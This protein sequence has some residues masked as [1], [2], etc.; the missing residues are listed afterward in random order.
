M[1]NGS[2]YDYWVSEE[3]LNLIRGWRRKGMSQRDI[4]QTIKVDVS[5]F[6]VWARKFPEFAEAIHT[7]PD[8]AIN[9]TENALYKSAVGYWV[10]EETKES[11][12]V[13]D[14][15]TRTH[16]TLHKRYIA[17]VL[18]AQCFILKNRDLEHWKDHPGESASN[19]ED[20]VEIVIDV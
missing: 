19:S 16:T 9:E 12:E 7:I 6:A 15:V 5:R 20:K 4:A 10:T 13:N 18:G 11:W 1:P 3:G 14:T 17:P 8:L 2:K